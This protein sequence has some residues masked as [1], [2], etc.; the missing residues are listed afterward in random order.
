MEAWY[1][2]QEGVP[3]GPYVRDELEQLHREG[4]LREEARVRQSH[5]DR[6][7]PVPEALATGTPNSAKPVDWSGV[8]FREKPDAFPDLPALAVEDD[9]WQQARPAPWRRY[10]GRV[11]DFV[12]IMPVVWLALGSVTAGISPDAYE[13]LSARGIFAWPLLS[14]ILA[15]LIAMTLFALLLGRTGS[16]PGKWLFGTR[17]TR[18]D[19]SAIGFR[20]A[21]AREFSVLA[22]GMGFGIPLISLVTN[23]YS[24][25]RLK[26]DGTTSWDGLGRWVVTHRPWGLVQIACVALALSMLLT[27]GAFGYL[28]GSNG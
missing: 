23:I 10:F 4:R 28:R 15:A 13:W 7:C 19:G 8:R 9:G 3:E 14:G 25:V 22:A 27:L 17:V 16:T 26:S 21:F 24:Y 12:V 2:L 20:A 1:L 5:A 6:W 11:F 18:H